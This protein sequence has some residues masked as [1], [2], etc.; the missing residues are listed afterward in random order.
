MAAPQSRTQITWFNTLLRPQQELK[1]VV[2][3]GAGIS[4]FFF[5]LLSGIVLVHFVSDVR[6]LGDQY[7]TGQLM[8]VALVLGPVTGLLFAAVFSFCLMASG[9]LLDS[10]HQAKFQLRPADPSWFFW[11]LLL[12]PRWSIAF[13]LALVLFLVF[14]FFELWDKPGLS[15]VKALWSAVKSRI[16]YYLSFISGGRTGWGRL[17]E[18]TGAAMVSIGLIAFVLAIEFRWIEGMQFTSAHAQTSGFPAIATRWLLPALQWALLGWYLYSMVRVQEFA[19][20]LSVQKA[21][22]GTLLSFAISFALFFLL[23]NWLISLSLTPS[24]F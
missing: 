20:R 15:T 22:L 4:S 17:H 16:D 21:L 24:F 19:F 23:L 9:C 11:L 14:R 12:W 6:N 2:T 7:A 3:E 18:S 5:S 1:K 10:S 8:S 13:P